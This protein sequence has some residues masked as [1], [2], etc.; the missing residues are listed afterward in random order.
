SNI[1]QLFSIGADSGGSVV[2]LTN[3]K[4]ACQKPRWSP[5][6]KYLVFSTNRGWDTK[7]K[8]AGSKDGTWN[9]YIV[10]PDGTGLTQITDGDGT[11]KDPFWAA[12]GH[13]YFSSDQGGTFDLWRL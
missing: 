12:D 1:P 3:D 2:Q 8:S 10:K 4:Y 6:G 13:I 11:S 5:D 9:V 7:T